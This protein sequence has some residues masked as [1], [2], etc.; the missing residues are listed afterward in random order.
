MYDV[1]RN[2]SRTLRF[3]FHSDP[4]KHPQIASSSAVIPGL[5]AFT[6]VE[7]GVRSVPREGSD[8]FTV[9]T[10]IILVSLCGVRTIPAEKP[11]DEPE[12]DPQQRTSNHPQTRLQSGEVIRAFAGIHKWDIS[13]PSFGLMMLAPESPVFRLCL[14]IHCNSV[15]GQED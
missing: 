12:V 14:S 8:R 3:S 9:S 13:N 5:A 7:D 4:L 2:S 6:E 11:D 1:G 10:V 15:A